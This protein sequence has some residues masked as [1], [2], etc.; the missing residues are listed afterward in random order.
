MFNRE[1]KNFL[2]LECESNI[3]QTASL[4]HKIVK[5]EERKDGLFV[6]L[7]VYG[8]RTID[9]Y[10]RQLLYKLTNMSDT[11]SCVQTNNTNTHT[12]DKVKFF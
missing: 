3:S 1:K 7:N 10:N 11:Q 2:F 8:G 4:I 12:G 9:G 6:G 5:M